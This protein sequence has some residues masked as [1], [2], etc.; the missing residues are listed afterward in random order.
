MLRPHQRNLIVVTRA[1]VE[2]RQGEETKQRLR[3]LRNAIGWNHGAGEWQPSSWIGGN[4]RPA[5]RIERPRKVAGALLPR[6][7]AGRLHARVSVSQPLIVECQIRTIARN[8]PRNL[9]RSAE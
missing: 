4:G 8:Q 3:L 7:H 5:Q 9:D 2:V 6:W 1:R